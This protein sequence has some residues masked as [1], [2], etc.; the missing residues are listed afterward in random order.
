[1]LSGSLTRVTRITE[2]PTVVTTSAAAPWEAARGEGVMT[3][4][5][6]FGDSSSRVATCVCPG[7]DPVEEAHRE[8]GSTPRRPPYHCN[9][10]LC[11]RDRVD[12]WSATPRAF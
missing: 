4:T 9:C 10:D 12:A 5:V 2:M 11:K 3:G 8:P 7:D 1:M 6:T